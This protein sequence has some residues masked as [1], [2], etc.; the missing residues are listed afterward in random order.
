MEQVEDAVINRW[1]YDSDHEME[2]HMNWMLERGF[3]VIDEE[4]NSCGIYVRYQKNFDLD[5]VV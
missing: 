2:S 3:K 4:D 1:R 5:N